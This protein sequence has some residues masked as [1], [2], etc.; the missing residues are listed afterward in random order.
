MCQY[1]ASPLQ[2]SIRIAH[3][4]NFMTLFV[5]DVISSGSYS[6]RILLKRMPITGEIDVEIR[7]MASAAR[8]LLHMPR[9]RLNTNEHVKY[10]KQQYEI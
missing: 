1:R 3:G 6:T 5:F 9:K 8:S 7:R 4:S 2:I 10:S